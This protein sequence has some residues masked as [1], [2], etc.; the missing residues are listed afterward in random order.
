MKILIKILIILIFVSCKNK[1]EES[2]K[3]QRDS[4]KVEKINRTETKVYGDSLKIIYKYSGDTIFQEHIDLKGTSDDNYDSSLNMTT[5]WSTRKIKEL[6]C[7]QKLSLPQKN[8]IFTYCVSNVIKKIENDI[9]NSKDEPWKLDRLEKL[10]NELVQIEKGTRDSLSLKSF[11][12]NFLL[13]KNVELS[14]YDKTSKRQADKIK[15]GKY[16]VKFSSGNS[17]GGTHYYFL[18]KEN[19]TIGDF[20]IREW[21]T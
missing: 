3:L 12:L 8:M 9:K 4:K 11:H 19:D 10:K 5:V 21:I 18:T 13:L 14:A 17:S 15:I 7:S 6:H 2:E 20:R 1:E 16:L